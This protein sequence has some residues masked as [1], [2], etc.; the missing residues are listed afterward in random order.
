MNDAVERAKTGDQQ[1]FGQLV[2]H[3][4]QAVYAT[5][6][7]ILGN[8]E[9]AQDVAQDCFV[10]A[11]RELPDLRETANFPAWL[12]RIARNRC[13]DLLRARKSRPQRDSRPIEEI[14]HALPHASTESP[15][16]AAQRRELRQAVLDAISALSEPN[17]LATT[18]FYIDGYSVDEVAEFLEIPSGTVKRRLHDSR[19]QLRERM[20]DMVADTLKSRPLPDDFTPQTVEKAVKEAQD[21]RSQGRYD[22]AE[23]LL[24][25]ILGKSPDSLPALRELNR[26]LM[27]G[28]IYGED[29]RN[30]WDLLSDIAEHGRRILEHDAED[31][32]VFCET[33]KTL[34]CIPAMPEAAAFIE[35]WISKR[36][37]SLERLGML[38]WARACMGLYDEADAAWERLAALSLSDT[39]DSVLR[40]IPLATHLLVD[41]FAAAGDMERAKRV[42]RSGRTISKGDAP[43]DFNSR[44]IMG[45]VPWARMLMTAGLDSEAVDAARSQH[46]ALCGLAAMDLEALRTGLFARVWFGDDADSILDD[47]AKNNPPQDDD[48]RLNGVRENASLLVY[49][50]LAARRMGDLLRSIR[51]RRGVSGEA[52]RWWNVFRINSRQYLLYGDLASAA[53]A[54]REELASADPMGICSLSDIAVIRGDMTPPEI[55][56]PIE[57]DG[58]DRSGIYDAW[59]HVARESAAA[60]Q[61]DK[62]FNT[63]QRA[64]ELWFNPPLY[65]QHL[66]EKDARW[67]SLREHPEFRRI[68]AERRKRIGPVL[69]SLWYFPGW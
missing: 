36:G 7:A 52:E 10:R 51:G 12:H 18:L 38:A 55:M 17:R 49:E 21:L 19:K 64:C 58:P 9:D 27:W 47:W 5:A 16:S 26:V 13:L 63:L 68:L 2:D 59:Y 14:E 32:R 35:D 56:Q 65:K 46:N 3:Y 45:Q 54:A 31:D 24:R 4:Q 48:S 28:S 62:A 41:C 6:Y 1:A 34:L 53:K 23:D 30:R 50:F 57:R 44:I 40:H 43:T 29:S 61:S 37:E 69:G 60:G 15:S 33:A 11:W 39:A 22:E 42:A 8:F 25:G 20:M 66:W 67:G